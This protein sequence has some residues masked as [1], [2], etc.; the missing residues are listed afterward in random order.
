MGKCK[1]WCATALTASALPCSFKDK[2]VQKDAK[3][4]SYKVVDKASKPYV[5]VT[6]ADEKKVR[7]LSS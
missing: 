2:E 7:T 1:L 6:I 4:V 3:I 5:E